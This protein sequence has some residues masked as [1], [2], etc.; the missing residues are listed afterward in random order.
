MSLYGYG[1]AQYVV[2]TSRGILTGGADCVGAQ[3]IWLEMCAFGCSQHP[4]DTRGA[5]SDLVVANTFSKTSVGMLQA[6]GSR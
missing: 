5:L 3:F 2:D 6:R 4:E 1:L